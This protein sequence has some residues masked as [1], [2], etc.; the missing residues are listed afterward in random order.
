METFW[1]WDRDRV[2]GGTEKGEGKESGEGGV[3]VGAG[4]GEGEK[5]GGRN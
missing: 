2:E 4:E 3:V 1:V 5:G